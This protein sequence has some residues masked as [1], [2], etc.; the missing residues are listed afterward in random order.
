ML[1][2]PSG[3]HTVS[4]QSS[5]PGQG[6]VDFL[7]EVCDPCQAPD[8]GY[9]VNG[10]TVSEFITPNHFYPLTNSSVRYSFKGAIT[11]PGKF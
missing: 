5:M 7:L 4:G 1:V 9:C 3:T 8:F 10:I 2:D 11:K 6:R